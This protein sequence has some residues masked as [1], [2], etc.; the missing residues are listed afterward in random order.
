M[1]TLQLSNTRSPLR[2]SH[3]ETVLIFKSTI[4]NV[5]VSYF[6]LDCGRCI[7]TLFYSLMRMTDIEFFT[8][9]GRIV[10][11]ELHWVMIVSLDY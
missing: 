8:I 11:S 2:G 4:R 9:H 5:L 10:L 6:L 1:C 7:A 3:T